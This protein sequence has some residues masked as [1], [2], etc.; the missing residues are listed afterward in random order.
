MQ[1]RAPIMSQLSITRLTLTDIRNHA[2]MR[3]EPRGSLIC[4]FGP[5]GAGKTNILEAVSLLAPGRGLRAQNFDLLG[6]LDGPGGWAVAAEIITPEGDFRIGT[7]RESHDHEA[8]GSARKVAID[9]QV[10]K[11]SGALGHYLKILW[12]T[13]GSLRSSWKP[14]TPSLV[15]QSLKS[16]SPK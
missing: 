5:N 1:P 13:P 14:V 10:Q 2:A 7:S 9:G 16:M 15:P 3:I 4:L 6:R 11:S 8:N 12:L